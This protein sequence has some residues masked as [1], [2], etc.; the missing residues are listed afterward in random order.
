MSDTLILCYHAVSER[1]DASISV[2][3]QRLHAQL[4]GLLERDY[5]ATTFTQAVLDPPAPRTLAVTF[6][7]AYRSVLELARPIL[8]GLG[9]VAT[10]YVPTDFAGQPTPMTWPGI[11]GWLGGPHERE[12]LPLGWDELGQLADSG[13]EVGSHTRTHPRLTTLTDDDALA[14]ELVDSR[15]A[16]TA[17]LGR[18]CRS[19]AYPYGDMDRRVVAMTREA[20][21][22]AG[23]A[24][25]STRPPSRLDWPRVG[26]YQRDGAARFGLKT[27][28]TVRRVRR[29]GA[30]L[31]ATG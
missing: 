6:D 9:I 13:W 1:W 7:D 27:S 12:L 15:A 29:G 26:I 17:A 24:I 23:G 16:V 18:P 22:E 25:G 2:A 21:Y 19:I 8:D 11:D 28:T 20:G 30:S 10:V 31:D 5:E 4:S 3:P 14:A